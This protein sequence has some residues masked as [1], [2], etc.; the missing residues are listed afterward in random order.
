VSTP[1]VSSRARPRIARRLRRGRTSRRRKDRTLYIGLGLIGVVVL[2]S[3]IGHFILPDPNEQDLLA[4]LQA[5]SPEHP[6]GTDELGRDVLSRTLAATWLDLPLALG[7]TFS[8]VLIGVAVGA[9]AGYFGG[10]TERI[11]MRL[12]DAVIAFPLM[13]FVLV[14][15]AV[16]GPGV[17][18]L[19]IAIVA[20]GWAIYARFGRAEMLALRE[21]QFIQAAKTLGYSDR[22]VL[23]RHAVPNLLR[24]IVVFST[25]DVVGAIMLIASLSFLGLGVTPPTPEWGGI[26][27]TGQEYLLTAWWISALPGVVL[28][29]VGVGFVLVGDALGERL[30]V[31]RDS[32]IP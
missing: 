19:V 7:C 23:L 28:V 17:R 18:G 8:S 1:L 4:P 25:S 29:I 5:P 13:V 26:I 15:I 2:A 16:A 9:S 22:R 30:G 27:A 24:P 3:A 12:T 32:V 10:W 6:F 21:K 14:V 31:E 11:L 20:F